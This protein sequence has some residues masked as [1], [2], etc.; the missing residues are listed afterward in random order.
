MGSKY[1]QLSLDDRNRLQRG[2][3]QGMSL[4]PGE[5]DGGETVSW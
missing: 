5:G 2:L 1:Q 3:S 4:R